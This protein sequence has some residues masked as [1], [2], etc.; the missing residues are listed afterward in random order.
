MKN[1]WL[2][3]LKLEHGKYYVGITSQTPE[4]RF[5][6]HKNR[7]LAASWTKKYPPIRIIQTKNLGHVRKE[8]A[9]HSENK[10]AREYIKK[11]GIDNVRG[12]DINYSGKYYNRFGR[13]V[14]DN[15]WE[16]ITV[17]SFLSLGF[18]ILTILFIFR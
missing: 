13:Y 1:W 5:L 18:L 4:K 14:K 3:T 2:Y 8:H 6:Q 12:G 15:D 16:A 17:V 9:E 11:Y 7:F 10:I